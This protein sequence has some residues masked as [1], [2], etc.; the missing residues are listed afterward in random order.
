MMSLRTREIA[1]DHASDDLIHQ[2]RSLR[3]HQRFTLPPSSRATYDESC[4]SA[5][6]IV[7]R[8]HL[9]YISADNIEVI[10][11]AY[12]LHQFSRCPPTGLRRSST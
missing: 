11:A 5:R 1:L 10:H 6:A 7:S 8:R 9:H 4:I 3:H 12:N 2:V